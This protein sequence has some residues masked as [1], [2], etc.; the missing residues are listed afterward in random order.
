[1]MTI[2]GFFSDRP[3][4]WRVPNYYRVVAPMHWIF[5]NIPTHIETSFKYLKGQAEKMRNS[6]LEDSPTSVYENAAAKF[7]GDKNLQAQSSPGTTIPDKTLSEP[8]DSRGSYNIF[9]TPCKWNDITGHIVIT[10]TTIRFIRQFPRKDLWERP[11]TS[12]LEIKKGDG[13]TAIVKKTENFMVLTFK[14]GS[15][16]TVEKL[17]KKDELFNVIVAFSGVTWQ[18]IDP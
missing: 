3:I 17:E 6:A 12:L 10:F 18:Q 15:V 14:D 16:E 5:W 11:F 4:S 9:V 1:L 13:K 8:I 7:E 2:L